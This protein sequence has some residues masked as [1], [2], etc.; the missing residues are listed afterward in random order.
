MSPVAPRVAHGR[1]RWLGESGADKAV[2]PYAW[3]RFKHEYL[4]NMFRQSSSGRVMMDDEHS[5]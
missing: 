2:A 5:E 4:D 1:W 3:S